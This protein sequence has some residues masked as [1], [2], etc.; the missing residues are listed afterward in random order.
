MVQLFLILASSDIRVKGFLLS[1]YSYSEA[2]Q[3]E[4]SFVSLTNGTIFALL[5]IPA[6]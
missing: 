3:L 4:A 1:T 2:L 6:F 5:H